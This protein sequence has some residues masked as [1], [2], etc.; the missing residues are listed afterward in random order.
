MV[1]LIDHGASPM[2]IIVY[3]VIYFEMFSVVTAQEADIRWQQLP[4]KKPSG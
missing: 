2:Y 3:P 1:A 4:V